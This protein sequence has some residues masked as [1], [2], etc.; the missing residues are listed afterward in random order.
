MLLI[1]EEDS[2]TKSNQKSEQGDFSPKN[3]E[4]YQ[5]SQQEE[6]FEIIET[7]AYDYQL[8][9]VDKKQ[10]LF[11]NPEGLILKIE[12]D[13]QDVFI[14]LWQYFMENP[15]SSEINSKNSLSEEI[16]QLLEQNEIIPQWYNPRLLR[17]KYQDLSLINR[18]EE[19]V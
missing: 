2:I 18:S 13:E 16:L 5:K 7:I 12:G 10:R 3:A 14:N 9:C 11:I 15:Q 6:L 1:L 8:E 4:E 19:R 17:K